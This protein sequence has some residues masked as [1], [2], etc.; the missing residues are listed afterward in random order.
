MT[1]AADALAALR[2]WT[3]NFYAPESLEGSST[4]ILVGALVIAALYALQFLSPRREAFDQLGEKCE[5]DKIARTAFSL[6]ASA[7]F[8]TLLYHEVSGSLLTMACGM[9]GLLLL[10]AGF[11]TRE[12]TLRYTGLLLFFA[13][14][15]KLFAWDMRHLETLARIISAMALGLLLTAVG[16]MYSRFRERI[17]PYL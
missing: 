2:G 12:R 3:T 17:R 13:C 1:A 9:Q 16:W 7:T 10:A 15:A 5:P 8:T 4:R 14:I 6:L 11:P